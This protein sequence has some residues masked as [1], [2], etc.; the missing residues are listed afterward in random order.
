MYPRPIEGDV[1]LPAN[2][3]WSEGFLPH[4]CVCVYNSYEGLFYIRES[5]RM[6]MM[7]KQKVWKTLC[8]MEG[9]L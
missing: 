5:L 8:R 7:E 9:K 4:G 6:T 3:F 2:S 1:S